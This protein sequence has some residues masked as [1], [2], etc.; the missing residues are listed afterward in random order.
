MT[1]SCS[2]EVV[3]ESVGVGVSR[4]LEIDPVNLDTSILQ[5]PEWPQ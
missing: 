5:M 1:A 2:S 4:V 3:N